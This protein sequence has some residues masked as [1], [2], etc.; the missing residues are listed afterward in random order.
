[1][2]QEF[3]VEEVVI[4]TKNLKDEHITAGRSYRVLEYSGEDSDKLKI[5]CA[6]WKS[7]YIDK[8]HFQKAN[9]KPVK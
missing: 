9:P 2:A 1:M 7:R 5:R 4:A 6:D 8:K 3:Q